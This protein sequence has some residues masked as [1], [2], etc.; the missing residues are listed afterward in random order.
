MNPKKFIKTSQQVIT[1][2][3]NHLNQ[4]IL[5]KKLNIPFSYS[6]NNTLR[7]AESPSYYEKG[8]DLQ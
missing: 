3:L 2:W 5:E 4:L 7:V 8:D 1:E 6:F